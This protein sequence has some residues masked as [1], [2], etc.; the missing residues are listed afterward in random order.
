M[1]GRPPRSFAASGSSGS[2]AAQATI[3]LLVPSHAAWGRGLLTGFLAEAARHRDWRLRLLREPPN[4]REALMAWW[5]LAPA[6]A[7][8]YFP[9]GAVRAESVRDLGVPAIA[10]AEGAPVG[11]PRI[12]PDD[13]RIGALAAA[14]LALTGATHAALLGSRATWWEPRAAG[15]RRAWPSGRPIAGCLIPDPADHVALDRWLA[16]LPKPL[17]LFCGN[18]DLALLAAEACL[19]IRAL[20]GDTVRVLGVDDDEVL[21]RAATVP[22]SSVRIPWVRLGTIAARS[23]A[24]LLAGRPLPDWQDLAPIGVAE[25]ASTAP[26]PIDDRLLVAVAQALDDQALRPRRL[27]DLLAHLP[28]SRSTIERRWRAH[29]GHS[30]L[31]AIHQRRIAHATDLLTQGWA[32]ARIAGACGFGTADALRQAF[33]RI[34]GTSPA[35]WRRAHGRALGQHRVG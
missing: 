4:E 15:F 34:L 1:A 23:V 32:V 33:H 17:A 7:V 31:H 14:H 26:P 10:L 18:D 13:G 20:A 24:R 3:A 8:V 28:A 12:G 16:T 27:D 2:S 5:R 30:L 29:H 11:L 25:R 35:A 9:R 19:R 22:L 21:C 6:D